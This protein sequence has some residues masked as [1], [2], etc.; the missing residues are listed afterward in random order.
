MRLVVVVSMALAALTALTAEAK[1]D[2]NGESG[3]KV[4]YEAPPSQRS[5]SFGHAPSMKSRRGGFRG[6]VS[7][8]FSKVGRCAVGCFGSYSPASNRHK[9]TA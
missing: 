4:L 3:P 5:P 1:M 6:A 7:K 8:G 2:K 9:N